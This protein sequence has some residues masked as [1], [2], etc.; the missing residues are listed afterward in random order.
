MGLPASEGASLSEK[1]YHSPEQLECL[2]QKMSNNSNF[3]GLLLWDSSFDQNNVIEGEVYSYY[4]YDI[5]NR[6]QKRKLD[7]AQYAAGKL[8]WSSCSDR[9][10]SC[11]SLK[12]MCN[13]P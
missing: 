10:R 4:V 5:L 9:W 8:G 3:G 2:F 13:L 12:H 7:C 6:R 11:T 1:N